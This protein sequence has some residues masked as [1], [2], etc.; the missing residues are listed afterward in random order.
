MAFRLRSIEFTAD[1]RRIVRD[2]DVAGTRLTI[3]RSA[4]NDL[5]LADLAVDPAHAAI[6]DKGEGR[7]G[8]RALG[9]LGFTVDGRSAMEADIQSATGAE[10][11]FGSYRI[12]IARDTDGTPLLTTEQVP[13]AE[14]DL[15]A[16]QGFSLAGALPGKRA[17]SWLLAGLVLL[18]F[19]AWPVWNNL[20]RDNAPKRDTVAGDKAWSSGPLSLAHHSLENKCEA[21]HVKP[22]EPVQDKTC[23]T[24][25]KDVHDHALP[26]RLANA[27]GAGSWGDQVQWR[28]A[29][30]FGKPGPGACSDCHTEHEGAGKMAATPQ[31]FCADCHGDLKTRLTDTRL[32][33]AADFGTLHPQFRP[34]VALTMGSDKLTRVSLDDS[35]REASGLSFPHNKHLD[36]RGGVAR[37]ALTLSAERG[38]GSGG[39][40]CADCHHKTPDGVR[41]EPIRM[42]RDCGSCHSLAFDRVGGVVRTLR[43]GNVD[44]MAADLAASPPSAQPI[45]TGRQRP[46]EYANTGTYFARFTPPARGVG[47]VGRALSRDGICGECHTAAASGGRFSVVPVTQ[48][49]RFMTHGWFDHAAHKQE[50]CTSCHKA[51]QSATSADVLLPDLRAC[52]TCHLGEDAAK[53]EV[54]SSCAMC[55]DYHLSAAAPRGVKPKRKN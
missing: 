47:T 49:T 9:T 51:Q 40:Q 15:D 32:G 1:G 27:R 22:F 52:R 55:H 54:P 13:D 34:A 36:P 18:A 2:R 48:V 3:G 23:Q 39:L 37:M 17:M 7:L 21:C 10:L 8:V 5:H 33:N 38:Y 25:H 42:E 31:Q 6:E 4:D 44:Q 53:A 46:G 30:M 20:T 14:G 11:R 26:G 24:C 35:P 50:K 19:L 29:H 43:H 16:K 41:F 12:S 45:V 28:V